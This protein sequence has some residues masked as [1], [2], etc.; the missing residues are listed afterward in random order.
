ML[1]GLNG[2]AARVWEL[3]D[4]SKSIADISNAIAQEYSAPVQ[5]VLPDVTFFV[6][7]LLAKGLLEYVVRQP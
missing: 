3:T 2:T 7:Q 6:E 5:R 4:G 1:R